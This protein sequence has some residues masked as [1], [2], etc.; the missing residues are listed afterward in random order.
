VKSCK[1]LLKS[2]AL[3]LIPAIAA[4]QQLDKSAPA[5]QAPVVP[6]IAQKPQT[7]APPE[8]S[9]QPAANALAPAPEKP[10][11][12]PFKQF[13]EI[14]EK[15]R[16]FFGF[17][18]SEMKSLP[19]KYHGEAM[20]LVKD[21]W[22]MTGPKLPP[23]ALMPVQN[24]LTGELI[25]GLAMTPDGKMVQLPNTSREIPAELAPIIVKKVEALSNADQ[26]LLQLDSA[27]SYMVDPK[28]SKTQ[29]IAFGQDFLKRF[30]MVQ[31]QGQNVLGL[32]EVNRLGG[33][34]EARFFNL[35]G[36]INNEQMF[37]TD[38]PRFVQQLNATKIIILEGRR[39]ALST[40]KRLSPDL[41]GYFEGQGKTS[42]PSQG[43]GGAVNRMR[44]D[45]AG[46]R[47]Q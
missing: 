36:L 11:Y 33:A 37:G 27:I 20:K 14:E 19:A 40:L 23:N 18:L 43:G 29:K 30:K 39:S 4:A 45:T 17:A 1:I 28:A 25:P 7:T 46:K 22:E 8:A 2:S 32:D 38:L 13:R 5:R 9:A 34:L 6:W 26:S 24:P 21:Y 44:F 15:K 10:Q 16:D 42:H 3:F 12:D 35:S 47:N 31:F 41:A